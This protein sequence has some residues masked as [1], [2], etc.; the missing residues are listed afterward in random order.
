MT[1]RMKEALSRL[2][3]EGRIGIF[4]Y[5]TVGFP[6]VDDT[7][8]LVPALAGAGVDLIELGMPF[9]DPLADGPTIQSASFQ[10]LQQGVTPAQCLEVCR[11]L[12]ERNLTIPLVLMGYYN[13]ILN[14]GL[15]AF[16]LDAFSS[17]VDGLIVPDL[18]PEEA[19]PLRKELLKHELSLIVMLAPTSTEERIAEVCGLAEGFVYC[20]SVTGVTGARSDIPPTAIELLERVR[21]HT[22]LPL[23]LGFGVS[24]SQHVEA[25]KGLAQ[26]VVV[27]SALINVIKS[28]TSEQRT[29]AA[30][31]FIRT[32][33]GR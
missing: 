23:A 9:S 5:L 26:A 6:S 10:A 22:K 30:V 32:L 18:P 3:S 20:V 11:T 19:M 17:G 33:N 29:E 28:A 7:I 12:R 31:R 24:Q 4:P 13:S 14:Y 1:E 8:E 27:G 16:A 25:V 15:E 2:M 21:R